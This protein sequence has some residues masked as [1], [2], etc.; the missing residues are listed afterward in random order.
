MKKLALYLDTSVLNFE[1]FDTTEKGVITK[2]LFGL[3]SLDKYDVYV[4]ALVVEEILDAPA[5]KRESLLE[6]I[7]KY[8]LQVLETT[9]DANE[10]ADK[11]V[12]QGIIPAKYRDD[13]LHIAI[14][15]VNKVNVIVS[16][17]FEHIVKLKTKLEVNGLNKFYGYTEI[18]ICTP[19]E[20]E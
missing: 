14:A 12:A 13:A 7:S 5:E 20:V 16:W 10:L 6:L 17:N 4:S 9:K 15:V 2:R 11:Y 1:L 18:E 8:E 19:E 3:F